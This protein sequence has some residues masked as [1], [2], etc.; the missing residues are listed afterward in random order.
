MQSIGQML[1][2]LADHKEFV[3]RFTLSRL[4]GPA[5]ISDCFVANDDLSSEIETPNQMRLFARADQLSVLRAR[6]KI[7]DF[8]QW[9]IL[10]PTAIPR[11]RD[12]HTFVPPC[13]AACQS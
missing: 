13:T 11:I 5:L 12:H 3:N 7:N 8:Q 9:H 10:R 6:Q 4:D 2:D 1:V